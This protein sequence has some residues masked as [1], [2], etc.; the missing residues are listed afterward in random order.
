MPPL[1][2]LLPCGL[3]LE[4]EIMNLVNV[5]DQVNHVQDGNGMNIVN[6]MQDANG[7]NIVNLVQDVNAVNIVNAAQDVNPW[8]E[9]EGPGPQAGR[10]QPRSARGE[11]DG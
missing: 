4:L 10:H 11:W 7:M 1:P 3:A 2:P 9:N 5:Q 6:H 8:N